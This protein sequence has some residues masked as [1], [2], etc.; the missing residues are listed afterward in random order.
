MAEMLQEGGILLLGTRRPSLHPGPSLTT[1]VTFTKLQNYLNVFVLVYK[2]AA[3]TL[4]LG[5]EGSLE[6]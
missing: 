1:S 6:D 2:M 3:I 5:G 4:Y